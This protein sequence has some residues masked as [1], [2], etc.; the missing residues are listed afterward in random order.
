MKISEKNNVFKQIILSRKKSYL[1]AVILWQ[2]ARY[3]ANQAF[4]CTAMNMLKNQLSLS[5]QDREQDHAS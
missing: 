3:F 4:V 5:A 1:I 2:I